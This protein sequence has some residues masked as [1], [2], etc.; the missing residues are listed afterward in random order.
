MKRKI[1]KIDEDL[2]DGCS[3]CVPEC[4]EGAL[5]IIDGKARLIS[6]LFC[7]GLGACL[8]ECPKNAICIEERE[9]EPYNEAKVMEYIVKSG[10]NVIIAHLNHL[11]LHNEIKYYNEGLNYLKENKIDLD[12]R[13][14]DKILIPTTKGCPGSKEIQINQQIPLLTNQSQNKEQAQ[15][16]NWPIQLHL[17]SPF[18]QYL[19]GANVLLS[20]DCVPFAYSEFDSK[21]L[22]GKILTIACPKLDSN[23]DVYVEKITKMISDSEIKSITVAIME[24]PCCSG[25]LSIVKSAM[26]VSGKEISV[27]II[28]IGIKGDVLED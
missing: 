27:N 14:I 11:K 2:C 4:A 25:L 21:L 8:G 1:V 23:K 13:K 5:Q 26:I 12:Y 6:D 7:D 10:E 3:N 24:V 18:A 22:N 16:S 17:I 20:A 9:A 28:K 15:L 19:K